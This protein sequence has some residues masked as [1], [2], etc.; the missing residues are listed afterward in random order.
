MLRDRQVLMKIV[1][2]E[3]KVIIC[4]YYVVKK[5]QSKELLQI[6][7]TLLL[8][9]SHDQ[10]NQWKCTFMKAHYLKRTVNFYLWYTNKQ[11]FNDLLNE[12]HETGVLI[13]FEGSE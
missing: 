2:L 13:A 12:F 10:L 6:N 1:T 3:D 4:L 8:V 9:Q 7:K 11:I 5:C